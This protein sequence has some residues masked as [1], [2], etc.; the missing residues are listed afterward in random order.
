[1]RRPSV[2]HALER[3]TRHLGHKQQY[4][5]DEEAEVQGS[6][7]CWAPPNRPAEEWQSDE[8]ENTLEGLGGGWAGMRKEMSA[9]DWQGVQGNN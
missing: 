6:Q 1:M 3:H 9:E 2:L 7:Q 4:K 5:R 8:G